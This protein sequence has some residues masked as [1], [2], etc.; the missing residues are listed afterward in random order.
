MEFR[1][2]CGRKV[3]FWDEMLDILSVLNPYMP[4]IV[5]LVVG[6]F[7]LV[8]GNGLLHPW[9]A[10]RRWVWMDVDARWWNWVGFSGHNPTGAV[11]LIKEII[12]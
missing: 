6:E 10:R 5:Q 11:K 2:I 7:E 1:M 12:N 9:S 4:V 8:E 3:E